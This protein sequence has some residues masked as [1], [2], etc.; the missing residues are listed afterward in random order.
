MIRADEAYLVTPPEGFPMIG[1]RVRHVPED[2]VWEFDLAGPDMGRRIHAVSFVSSDKGGSFV[3]KS[4]G[5][6]RFERLTVANWTAYAEKHTIQGFEVL[7]DQLQTDDALQRF[8]NL[9][10]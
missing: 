4:G 2:N 7:R 1:L 5:V 8:Y 3:T 9:E 10:F 6:W